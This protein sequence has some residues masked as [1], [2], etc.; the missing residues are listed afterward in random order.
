MK[1]PPSSDQVVRMG[2]GVQV[3]RALALLENRPTAAA[4][5]PQ[6]AEVSQQVSLCPESSER[7]RHQFVG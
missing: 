4:S 7:G 2:R 6:S 3:G 5:D 1:G